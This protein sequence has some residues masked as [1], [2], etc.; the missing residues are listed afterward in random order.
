[1]EHC[2]MEDETKGWQPPNR[3]MAFAFEF[4]SIVRNLYSFSMISP[5]EFE[6]GLKILE[7]QINAYRKA[8]K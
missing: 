7:M 6:K 2:P 4:H 8:A 5:K 3:E 1:M